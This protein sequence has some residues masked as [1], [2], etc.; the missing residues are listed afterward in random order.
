MLKH[1]CQSKA[2]SELQW[3]AT[4]RNQ[5]AVAGSKSILS[6]I[7]LI[8]INYEQQQDKNR[9]LQLITSDVTGSRQECVQ[10]GIIC[11]RKSVRKHSIHASDFK[12]QTS[13]HRLSSDVQNPLLLECHGLGCST[14]VLDK[15]LK[16][17]KDS[18]A[19]VVDGFQVPAMG[20]I[21]SWFNLY[22]D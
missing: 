9:D 5:L 2:Q 18:T 11:W 3:S 13:D 4:W 15:T 1:N 17:T 8:S 14:E 6:T 20:K 22:C 12:L 19:L 21:K 7:S 16:Q 10:F